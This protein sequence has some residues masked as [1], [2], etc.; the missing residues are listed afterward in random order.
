MRS[1][2]EV[3]QTALMGHVAEKV[4]QQRPSAFVWHFADQHGN[5]PSRDASALICSPVHVTFNPP[6][7]EIS[8]QA[9]RLTEHNDRVSM[10]I[11]IVTHQ[12][13]YQPHSSPHKYFS[14]LTK[15]VYRRDLYWWALLFAK[16]PCKKTPQ[17]LFYGA[18]WLCSTYLHLHSL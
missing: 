3:W 18:W 1:L 9:S 4:L 7:A 5:L 6:G 11:C 12:A 2:K 13:S 10:Y 14:V 17:V 8:P 15:M 16:D